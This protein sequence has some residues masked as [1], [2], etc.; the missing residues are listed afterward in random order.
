MTSGAKPPSP[1]PRRQAWLTG[2]PAVVLVLIVYTW[3]ASI[4]TWTDWPSNSTYYDRLA[5]AFRHGHLWLDLKPDA[6]L[7]ALPNPYDPEA[8]RGLPFLSDASLFRGRYYLYFGPVPALVLLIAKFFHPSAIADQLLVFA[9]TC[10]TFIVMSTF[11]I[12]IWRRFFGDVSPWLVAPAIAAL[13]LMSPFGW[14]LGSQAAVH[15]AAISAGQ[16][17]FLAGLY[18]AF[19]ALDSEASSTPKAVLA[20]LLW[21]AAIGSRITQIIPVAF[22]LAMVAV[23]HLWRR[24][25]ADAPARS[26]RAIAAYIAPVV[27][28]IGIL[29]WY[30]WARFGSVLETGVSYQ[31]ALLYVQA[32]RQEI[33]S[34]KYVLQNLYNY[35]LMPAKLRYNFPYI[36]P[37]M[38]IRGA[39]NPGFPLPSLYFAENITGLLFTAPFLVLGLVPGIMRALRTSRLSLS[40]ASADLLHW[41]EAVLAGAFLIGFA[42][43]LVFFWAS[44]RYLLDFLPAALLLSL[45]GFWRL[46]AAARHG[47]AGPRIAIVAGLVLMLVSAVVSTLLAIA[48]NADGFRQLNPVLWQQLNNLFRP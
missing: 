7:L 6:A 12:R 3:L 44:E 2:L 13:G 37:R 9:F 41:L 27:V 33:F 24:R 22:V 48:L 21:A 19:E 32:H 36:W 45:I 23:R 28:G 47:P 30:N 46:H 26:R 17:F 8:R 34:T 1:S 20:G 10:G 38:G 16:F 40:E 25:D 35:F 14:V 31:L 18:A 5:T 29:G 11:A 43:F 4:G 42:L 15:D 39:I